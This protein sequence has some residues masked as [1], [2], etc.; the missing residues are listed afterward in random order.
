MT[1]VIN[2][3]VTCII[4]KTARGVE[5]NDEGV[6][7]FCTNAE[8]E[9]TPLE[10][11]K[12]IE[13]ELDRS[14]EDIRKTGEGKKYDC[15]IGVSG[16]RDSTFL[17]HRLVTKH[18]LRCIAAYY[19]TPFTPPETDDNVKR[20]TKNLDV[21]LVEMNL[22]REYHWR[23]ARKIAL[24]WKKRPDPVLAN[25]TCA[26]CKMV[27]VELFRV[28]RR[29]EVKVIAIGV[30]KYEKFQLGAGQFKANT[31]KG[32]DSLGSMAAKGMIL[33]C[34]GF[35]LVAC[36]MKVWRYIPLG[37]KASLLYLHPHMPYLRLRFPDI[38]VFNYFSHI[39]WDEKACNEAL[40]EVGWKLPSGCKSTWKSDCIFAELKNY[41]FQKS[42]GLTYVDALFS[43]MIRH[44]I[45]TREEALERCRK[46]G[47]ISE[48]RFA[49]L[50][51][52]LKL[53]V[54]FFER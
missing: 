28:A 49:E 14:I 31:P 9:K 11:P 3:C 21:P 4:P 6:C 18:N 48:E 35:S 43:N 24:I 53:P 12:E 30:N 36:N 51:R 47:R 40:D 39:D 10:D 34:K 23:I 46:E 54:G 13:A 25:L 38:S 22:S 52:I 20:I 42:A 7:S 26:P 17:L 37:F 50:E 29:H 19:R 8:N 44:R 45:L 5:F 32:I 2:R 41:M 15:L 1:S 33:L 27:N 16:G